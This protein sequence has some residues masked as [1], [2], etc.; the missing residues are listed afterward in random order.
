LTGHLVISTLHAGSCAGVFERLAAFCPDVSAIAGS[1]QLILN[2]RLVRKL[3]GQCQG[4]GCGTCLQ[5]G[6]CG[7]VPLGEY[8]R[9]TPELRRCIAGRQWEQLEAKPTLLE[10]A[11]KLVAEGITD[12][13][14]VE[15]VLGRTL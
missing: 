15:R 14:E 4:T 2:Q 13:R 12:R 1:A 9:V 3:C 11:A 5:T 6:Y 7:R 8:L 10:G